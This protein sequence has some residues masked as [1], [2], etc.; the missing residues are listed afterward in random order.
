MVA[1]LLG[2]REYFQA[3]FILRPFQLA[4]EAELLHILNLANS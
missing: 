1:G 3:G 4:V 2:R